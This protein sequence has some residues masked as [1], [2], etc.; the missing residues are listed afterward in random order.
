MTDRKFVRG[1]QV[2]VSHTSAHWARGRVGKV[3]QY[4]RPTRCRVMLAQGEDCSAPCGITVAEADL[5][6]VDTF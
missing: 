1:A 6:G 4:T 5:E 3:D 2:L